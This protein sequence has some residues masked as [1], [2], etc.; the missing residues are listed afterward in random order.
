MSQALQD[1]QT[2]LSG[3]QI[4]SHIGITEMQRKTE[5]REAFNKEKMVEILD[6][7]ETFGVLLK[8]EIFRSLQTYIEQ[9]EHQVEQLQL[10]ALFDRR[11]GKMNWATGE[12]L[13]DKAKASLHAREDL[14]RGLLDGHK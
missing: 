14:I 13:K 6:R 8:P 9:L 3:F 11:E 10:E 5:W 1:V 7:N 2:V 12:D 4:G